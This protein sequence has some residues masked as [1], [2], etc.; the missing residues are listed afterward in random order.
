LRWYACPENRAFS[1]EAYSDKFTS[2]LFAVAARLCDD[3][4]GLTLRYPQLP[5]VGDLIDLHD[6]RG[7]KMSGRVRSRELRSGR[8]RFFLLGAPL[9]S[10]SVTLDLEFGGTFTSSF[11]VDGANGEHFGVICK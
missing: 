1:S 3:E 10:L 11:R 2:T 4:E 7:R 5:R 6:S 8:R 9:L